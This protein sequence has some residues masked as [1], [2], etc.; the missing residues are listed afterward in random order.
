M[1]PAAPGP[2]CAAASLLQLL[3]SILSVRQGNGGRIEKAEEMH[4]SQDIL[5]LDILS[6][7]RCPHITHLCYRSCPCS[8]HREELL[9]HVEDGFLPQ[10]LPPR[11]FLVRGQVPNWLRRPDSLG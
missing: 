3:L 10:E 2:A 9:R 6:P 4:C 1:G 11:P 5:T 7:C 8:H